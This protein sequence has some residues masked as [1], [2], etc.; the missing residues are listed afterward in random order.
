[1]LVLC[2][3]LAEITGVGLV[4]MRILKRK[5]EA[6]DDVAPAEVMSYELVSR[7]LR[8]TVALTKCIIDDSRKTPEQRAAEQLRREA[9]QGRRAEAAEQARLEGKRDHAKRS[10]AAVIKREACPS[11]RE[12]LLADLHERLL[13]PDI[14]T[15]LRREDVS[16]VAMRVLKDLRIAPRNETWSDALMAYEA[17]VAHAELKR[18]EAERAAGEAAAAEGVDWREGVEF[19]PPPG[20]ET[21]R[22][23]FTFGPDGAVSAEDPPDPPQSAWPPGI[24]S[25]RD[26]P[27]TG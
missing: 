26:P 9:D 23:R 18:Y 4:M 5:I 19:S 25:G 3:T 6:A 2:A 22:G 17:S 12:Y 27:D 20:V 11:D 13:H 21:K 16:A 10:A 7:S 8:R 24:V 14:D 1:M 15:A